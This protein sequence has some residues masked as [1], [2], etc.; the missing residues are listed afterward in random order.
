MLNLDTP[1]KLNKAAIEASNLCDRF[2]LADLSRIGAY[3]F[4]C[5]K[6]DKDSRKDWER[7]TEAAMDLAMQVQQDKS[8][9]WQGCSNI[10]FPLVTIAALQFHAR[11]YPAIVNGRSVVQ[12]RTIGPDPDGTLDKRARRISEHMSWQ[13]LEQDEEWEEGVDRLLI[14]VPIVGCA[15]KKSYYDADKGHNVSTLVLA[16]DFV[17]N[18]WAKSVNGALVK[19]HII[20]LSRNTLHSRMISGV[21]EDY[22]DADWYKLPPTVNTSEQQQRADNRSGVTAPTPDDNTPF[23][24]LEQHIS[25]DLDND[26]YA[27]PYIITIEE[28]TQS[29]LRIVCRFEREED[30]DRTASGEIIRIRATEYFT[31]IPF[32]PSPDGSIYDTG[33][34]VLIGPLNESTN[35]AINQLFDAGTMSNTAG[36]FLGRGAKIRGGVYQF[37]PFGW[38]RVDSTGDDLRKSLVPLPVRE[39]SAVLF[40]LLNL[41]ID[42]TNRISGSTD[43]LAGENPGQNTPAETSRAMVEQGQKIYS[44][45]FKR[46]WRAFKHEFTKLYQLN[47]VYLKTKAPFGDAGQFVLREDY[48]DSVASVVPVA[49]PTISSDG[50]RFAKARLVREAASSAAGYNN[51]EVEREY[52]RTLGVENIEKIFPGSAGMEPAKDVKL[53]IQELKMQ[54]AERELEFKKLSFIAN[55]QEQQRMNAAKIV[56]LNAKAMKLS[57]D[58]R[59]VETS[60]RIQAFNAAIGALKENNAQLHSQ[61]DTMMKDMNNDG[62]ADD[63][64]RGRIVQGL[65]GPPSNQGPEAVSPETP[66]G[67]DGTMGGGELLGSV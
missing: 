30:I 32:I 15:F 14:N 61:I 31:K 16:K 29:V 10:A 19:T 62:I 49:D 47:G 46:I 41:L 39:P 8:F 4:D 22:R 17:I 44:A 40:N 26:G 65:A 24:C 54:Q 64:S 37:S 55:M 5:Y 20:P 9:P 58:A 66:T 43:M 28:S 51:D 56:E 1:L 48:T 42:Y 57:E 27:E 53:Q 45:I 21:Y 36:G 23:Q 59:T 3:V 67:S 7:R 33:F 12:C 18:Y 35:S 60:Q 38:N 52:L 25:L 13:L 50:A 63:V 11:A 6:T 34:G 2:E